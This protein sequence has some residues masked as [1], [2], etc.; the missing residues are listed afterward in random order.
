[1]SETPNLP[2]NIICGNYVEGVL[3][4][5]IGKFVRKLKHKLSFC[6]LHNFEYCPGQTED[7][8]DDLANFVYSNILKLEVY[9]SI[10]AQMRKLNQ[11]E[12]L[13]SDFQD[14]MYPNSED[15]NKSDSP[16]KVTECNKCDIKFDSNFPFLDERE[17]LR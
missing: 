4:K 6:R 2:F 8:T 16:F 3:R 15:V 12:D 17:K 1:M 5:T 14:W 7:D 13:M 11:T 10:I 9:S